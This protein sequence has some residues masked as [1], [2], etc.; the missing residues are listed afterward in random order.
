MSLEF[1]TKNIQEHLWFPW[2]PMVPSKGLH[3]AAGDPMQFQVRKAV[4]GAAAAAFDL[5][6]PRESSINDL[7]EA[8]ARDPGSC[9]WKH[10]EG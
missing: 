4:A 10:L 5:E 2:F 1:R 7:M 8:L 9:I 6:M 3:V